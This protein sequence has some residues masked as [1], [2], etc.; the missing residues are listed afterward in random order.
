MRDAG[1]L[2]DDWVA[3]RGGALVSKGACVDALVEAAPE[4][5]NL[6]V[7]LRHA[8]AVPALVAALARESDVAA[9][10]RDEGAVRLQ[11]SDAAALA[12]AAGRAAVE[13]DVDIAE[14]RIDYGR[15]LG[16]DY[17]T[18]PAPAGRSASGRAAGGTP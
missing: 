4:G 12:R 8:G 15:Y 17:D 18:P 7:V 3:L 14:L 6:R 10:E 16:I 13:A 1:E 2:A 5:A 11:G 9:I